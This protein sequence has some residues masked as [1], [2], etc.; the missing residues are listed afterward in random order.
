M[1][2]GRWAEQGE[3]GGGVAAG[4]CLACV[5]PLI[6]EPSRVK[7][8]SDSL[9]CSRHEGEES[10]PGLGGEGRGHGDIDD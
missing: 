9:N 10:V 4:T 5:V 1:P 3:A 6:Q 8:S 7:E 2:G